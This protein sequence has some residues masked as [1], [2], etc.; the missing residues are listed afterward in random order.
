MKTL[1]RILLVLVPLALLGCAMEPV[2]TARLTISPTVPMVARKI[3]HPLYVV[4]DPAQVPD[5]Y[6]IPERTN[7]EIHIH[8]IHEFIR[9]DLRTGLAFLFERVVVIAPGTPIPPGTLVAQVR[10]QRFS[11]DVDMVSTGSA[12][13]A[14]VYGQM[15]WSLAIRGSSATDFAFSHTENVRGSFPLTHVSQTAEMMTSTY[16]LAIEHLLAKLAE[17]DIVAKLELAGAATTPP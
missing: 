3:A 4:L 13:A 9:R 1:W 5:R 11:A 2:H 10:I 16:Q 14:R 12:T 17:P 8:E 7:K 15:G 6:T